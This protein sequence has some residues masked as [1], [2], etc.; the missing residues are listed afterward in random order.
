MRRGVMAGLAVAALACGGNSMTAPAFPVSIAPATT[1]VAP[2]G[3]MT[4]TASGATS[5]NYTWSALSGS[6]RPATDTTATYFAPASGTD[7]VTVRAGSQAANASVRVQF[8]DWLG[9][10]DGVTP[11][12]GTFASRSPLTVTDVPYVATE[13]AG[14]ILCFTLDGSTCDG[15]LG[16]STHP[17]GPGS[18]VE[19][20][21]VPAPTVTSPVTFTKVLLLLKPRDATCTPIDRCPSYAETLP[22][23][24]T[25]T[26]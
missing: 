4:F 14:L 8:Q 1:N 16:F 15:N 3:T 5:G 25:I 17:M 11:T 20:L 18:G 6:I 10:P 12:S 2:S 23:N 19:T 7:T 26:P 22:V 9:A 13:P 21:S 24:L